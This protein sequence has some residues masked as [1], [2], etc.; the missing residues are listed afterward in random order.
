VDF[1]RTSALT[2]LSTI[3]SS[4]MKPEIASQLLLK[5]GKPQFGTAGVAKNDGFGIDSHDGVASRNRVTRTNQVKLAFTRYDCGTV[6]GLLGDAEQ[7][8]RWRRWRRGH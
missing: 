3:D 5:Q 8:Q 2:G 1:G 4:L 6:S 7:S